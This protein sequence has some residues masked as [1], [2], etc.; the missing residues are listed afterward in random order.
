MMSLFHTQARINSSQMASVPTW[1]LEDNIN[2][3]Q[4]FISYS[5]KDTE[6]VERLAADLQSTGLEV[7]YDLSGLEGGTRWGSEIQAAIEQSQYFL[8]VLSPNSLESKWV[9][10]EFLYAEGRNLK[11]IPLQYLPCTLPMWLLDLMV[12]D[13]QGRN[14]DRNFERLVKALGVQPGAVKQLVEVEKPAQGQVPNRKETEEKERKAYQEKQAQLKLEERQLKQA[15]QELAKSRNQERKEAKAKEKRARRRESWLK[16]KP[17]LPRLAGLAGL[18]VLVILGVYFLLP[19]IQGAMGTIPQSTNTSDPTNTQNPTNTSIIGTVTPDGP[20]PGEKYLRPA[21]GMWMMY[22]PAGSFTMGG[23]SMEAIDLCKQ[24]QGEC[25]SEWFNDADPSHEVSLYEFWMDE[26][27]VTNGLYLKCK[28]AGACQPPDDSSSSTR[29]SYYDNPQYYNYPVINVSWQDAVDYCTWAGAR[30]PSEQEWEMTARGGSEGRIFPWGNSHMDSFTANYGKQPGDTTEAGKYPLGVSKYGNFDMAGNVWEWV[31]DWYAAYPGGDPGANSYFGQTYKV[32]R[33]GS[34][35]D[36]FNLL[37]VSREYRI[38]DSEDMD[39]GFRCARSKNESTQP[40]DQP[41]TTWNSPK[42]GMFMVPVPAGEFNMGSDLD[43]DFE[44]PITKLY[45]NTFWIDFSEVTNE[46]YA[47]CVHAGVC[48]NIPNTLSGGKKYFGTDDFKTFPVVN[49]TFWDAQ[50]YCT[51]AGRRLPSEAE[52]EKA[53]RGTD[54]RTYPWGEGIDKNLANYIASGFGGPSAVGSYPNVKSP[55]GV[56]DMAGNVAE[57]TRSHAMNYPYVATDGR[58]NIGNAIGQNG[59]AVRG[60]SWN[61]GADIL[62]SFHREKINDDNA[63]DTI[64]FRCASSTRP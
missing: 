54:E 10:R 17:K 13:L 41:L 63:N 7:W 15:E 56:L 3:T 24:V 36:P 11:V 23:G 61:T 58:E 33:G 28:N 19:L 55:Y 52:W 8:V 40:T 39:I 22:I 30:L 44:K 21:D 48:K 25:L 4:V 35:A 31:Q 60:G 18:G 12:I 27:E 49:V 26:T 32:M 50:T 34:W 59:L 38:P 14:Y 20:K 53:A 47:G 64:G 6:F 45:L 9:Q 43:S 16:W 57:W 51:W 29:P 37:T 1:K 2:M 46:L 5:R 62:R 42:D